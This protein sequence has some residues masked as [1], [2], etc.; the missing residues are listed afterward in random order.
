MTLP[1]LLE[2]ERAERARERMIAWWRGDGLVLHAVS[3]RDGAYPTPYPWEMHFQHT[4]GLD[5]VG[6]FAGPV[7]AETAWRDGLRRVRI[8]EAY[9]ARTHFGGDALACFDSQLGPGSLAAFLG[10]EPEFAPDTVWFHPRT[11]DRELAEPLRF[12]PDDPWFLAQLAIVEAG[13]RAA[14]GRYLV[15]MPDLVENLDTLASLR[16]VEEFL[17]DLIERP[18]LVRAR[19]AQINRAY[20][21]AFDR[22]LGAL[23]DPWGG[24]AYSAFRIWGPGKTATVQC[25]ASAMISPGMFAEF[26]VP[27][28]EE[29]CAWL[30][31]SLYHLDGTQAVRH[32]DS[33]LALESLAAIE[34]TPQAGRP[35]GGDPAWFPLYRRI[36]EAGKSVQVLEVKPA[37][38]GPLLDAIGTRGVFLL[39]NAATE[40]E[41]RALEAAVDAYR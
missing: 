12:D 27:A 17:V 25:D 28:L 15:T 1:D 35:G 2:G 33:L 34:W 23:R 13:A 4:S 11:G 22:L 31:F 6:C 10:A 16:G 5:P 21:E 38:V 30:D 19:I 41:A 32:L 36:L 3:P 29:Q 20:F 9:L 18:D 14:Q 7:P 37:E 40:S 26:V 8:A 24:N 39:C